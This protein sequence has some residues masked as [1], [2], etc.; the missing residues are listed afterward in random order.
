[1]KKKAEQIF[2]SE[3]RPNQFP[4]LENQEILL[5]VFFREC[6]G[7]KRGLKAEP[8]LRP[9][10]MDEIQRRGKQQSAAVKDIPSQCPQLLHPF[11]IEFP[12]RDDRVSIAQSFILDGSEWQGFALPFHRKRGTM[13]S[14]PEKNYFLDLALGVVGLIC[15]LTGLGLKFHPLV[16]ET[17]LSG[18]FMKPLHEWSGYIVVLLVLLHLGMH[19]QW[20]QSFTQKIF[21]NPKKIFLF[22]MTVI[23]SAALCWLAARLSPEPAREWHK[24]PDFEM[25]RRSDWPMEKDGEGKTSE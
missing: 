19:G 15:V 17:I 1:L 7:E 10:G 20:L 11:S 6:H 13:F 3:Y 22:F 9:D 5:G 14:K 25:E 4:V 8:G 21:S 16:L 23:V 18:K 12:Y 24:G 2:P